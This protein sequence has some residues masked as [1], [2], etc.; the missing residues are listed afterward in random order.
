KFSDPYVTLDEGRNRMAFDFKLEVKLA[1]SSKA[2]VG[3]VKISGRPEFEAATRALFLREPKIEQM[4]FEDM[5]D[6]MTVAVTRA[7]SSL[8]KDALETKPLHVFK[9]EDFDKLG[10]A[11]EPEKFSIRG[12]KLV[13]TLKR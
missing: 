11:F 10:S 12:D 8:A 3:S 7:A 13:L 9:P 5:N 4:R 6:L 1:L 2:R